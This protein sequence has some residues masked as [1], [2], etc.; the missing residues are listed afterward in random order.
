MVDSG[1]VVGG[2]S[3]SDRL[4]RRKGL[5]L[6]LACVIVFS[7]AAVLILAGDQDAIA[8]NQ[9]KA[10]ILYTTHDPI[11]I[12]SDGDWVSAGFPGSGTEGDPYVI[13]GY[14]VTGVGGD[15]IHIQDTAVHFVIDDCYAHGDGYGV[16]LSNSP[17]ATLTNNN[18]SG[19]STDKK[20]LQS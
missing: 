13:T 11:Y 3:G 20:S 8:P 18:C 2:S 15:A 12:T 6:A 9:L 5:A 19:N 4:T 7:S 16:Y 1:H 17:N 10:R 14:D